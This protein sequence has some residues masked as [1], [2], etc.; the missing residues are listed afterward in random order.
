MG[1]AFVTDAANQGLHSGL[2]AKSG[3]HQMDQL[4]PKMVNINA[5]R[6]NQA[7]IEGQL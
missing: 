4:Y 1:C 2:T 5:L 6:Q 7:Q 3:F